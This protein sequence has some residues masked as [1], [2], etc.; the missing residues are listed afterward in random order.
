MYEQEFP[1]LV[2]TA[3]AKVGGNKNKLIVVSIP[4]YAFTPF[5]NGSA[6]ITSAL[7]QYN[8]FAENYCATNNITF[9]NIT[10]ITQQ[11]IINPA[12][13]ASDGL[14]PSELAY[15]KFV[16]RILPKAKIVLGL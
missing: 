5:G 16:E 7:M 13:V 6:S 4:D 1:E 8:N 3:I 10:D 15:S 12:L 11:G 2:N 9:V 14:H